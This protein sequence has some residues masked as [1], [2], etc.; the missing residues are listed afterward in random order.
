LALSIEDCILRAK[1]FGEGGRFSLLSLF[2]SFLDWDV[3]VVVSEVVEVLIEFELFSFPDFDGELVLVS[4]PF[5][6]SLIRVFS[7]AF[8]VVVVWFPPSKSPKLRSAT[9]NIRSERAPKID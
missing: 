7:R 3:V 9:E 8:G 4:S 5:V 6:G 2:V 1:G